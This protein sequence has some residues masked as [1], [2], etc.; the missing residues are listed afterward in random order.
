MALNESGASVLHWRVL[1]L[2][3]SEINEGNFREDLYFRVTV[4]T[5]AL[6]PLRAR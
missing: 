2:K 6:T 5:I 3:R 4:F 1:E